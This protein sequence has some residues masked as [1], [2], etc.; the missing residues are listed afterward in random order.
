MGK[1]L[2]ARFPFSGLYE[3]YHM[4]RIVDSVSW[5]LFDCPFEELTEDDSIDKVD[6]YV[7]DNGL[8]DKYCRE[9]L[10]SVCMKYGLRT[11]EFKELWSPKYY[12]YDT[13]AIYV[14]ISPEEL[15]DIVKGLDPKGLAERVKANHSSFPG[16]VSFISNDIETW[17]WEK[18]DAHQIETI[19]EEHIAQRYPELH[20]IRSEDKNEWWDELGSAYPESF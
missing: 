13:D 6:S 2:E 15:H 4:V 8:F 14:T 1:T 7:S 12:N 9:Y 10:E 17:D 20:E 5:L 18:L 3:T 16:F 11:V 19:L